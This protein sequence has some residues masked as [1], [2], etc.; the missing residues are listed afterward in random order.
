MKYASCYERYV[1]L[2]TE[3]VAAMRDWCLDCMSGYFDWE[4][5]EIN[6]ASDCE[7][8]KWV[9][10]QYDGGVRQFILDCA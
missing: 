2:T 3:H 5:D 7:I 8:V 9:A 6:E 10:R 1:D 4:E